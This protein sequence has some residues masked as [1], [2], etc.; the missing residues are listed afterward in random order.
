MLVDGRWLLD[1]EVSAMRN[2][3]GEFVRPDAKVRGWVSDD[4]GARHP[5][6]AGR[7]H[8]FGA[9]NCPWS[10]RCFIAIGLLGLDDVLTTSVA[11]YRRNEQ[12][13]WYADGIDDLQPEDGQLPLHRVYTRGDPTY[14][15]RATLPVLYDR[16][17]AQAISNES[18]DI[19]RM[20]NGPLAPLGHGN[21]DL[22]P[23]ELRST[24]DELN[25]WV[26]RDIN[27]GVY[28][29]G[30]ARAQEAYDEAFDA[31]FAALDRVDARLDRHRFLAGP[32][33][34]EAD[35]RLFPTLVRFDPVYYSHFK[36]NQ[37]RIADYPNLSGY[38]RDLYQREPFRRTVRVDIYKL[39]YYGRSERL[40]P[41]G[42]IPRGPAL[43]WD[44]PHGRDARSYAGA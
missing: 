11:H 15:G 32:V 6:A 1:E 44:R 22:Y 34:T 43:G 18:A 33:L 26:Y 42:I 29:A 10:Q 28:R 12:G 9:H 4:E 20:L 38:L 35:V 23:E 5:P 30:F 8:L 25:A 16:E 13:W 14:T 37:R 17:R 24:I 31:L 21:V 39:G 41:S 27:N 36:C 2:E 19:L 40:N 7:Y 3:R